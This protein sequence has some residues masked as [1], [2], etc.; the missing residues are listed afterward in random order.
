[1]PAPTKSQTVGLLSGATI[2]TR[3]KTREQQLKE[4]QE[5]KDVEDK[6]AADRMMAGKAADPS[7]NFS[8]GQEEVGKSSDIA[9][10]IDKI[11]RD[12]A[13]RDM[14]THKAG[15]S[16][17]AV[18]EELAEADRQIAEEDPDLALLDE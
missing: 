14:A 5:L 2:R 16:S 12:E 11:I 10:K 1:M 17:E 8:Q 7:K 6:R 15:A 18:E 4:Y 13:M 3:P 9:A